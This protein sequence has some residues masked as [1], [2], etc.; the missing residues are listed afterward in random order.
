MS[1]Q[2]EL[3]LE[4]K[5][6]L[7]ARSKLSLSLRSTG[8]DNSVKY[9]TAFA[10]AF[11]NDCAMVVGWIPAGTQPKV[12]PARKRMGLEILPSDKIFSAA[13]NK[14][15]ARTTTDVVPSP[16]SISCAADSSTSYGKQGGET[17]SPARHGSALRR[18]TIRAAGCRTAMCFKI[19]APSLVMTTS[20]FP[21][22]ICTREHVSTYEREF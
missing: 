3:T 18:H 7:A 8:I 4:F 1:V 22:W 13:A 21:V 14:L 20:P 2:R 5:L 15:P 17:L 10:A 11:W 9:S 16:A 19:V 12:S 6:V